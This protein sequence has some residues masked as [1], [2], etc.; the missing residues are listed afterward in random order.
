MGGMNAPLGGRHD[1]DGKIVAIGVVE[2]HLVEAGEAFG[3]DF[4]GELERH[5]LSISGLS[6]SVINSRARMRKPWLM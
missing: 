5:K 2:E 4:V 6:S 1:A 3:L